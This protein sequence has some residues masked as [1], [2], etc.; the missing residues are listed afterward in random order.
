MPY[1]FSDKNNKKRFAVHITKEEAKLLWEIGEMLELDNPWPIIPL[2]LEDY[3]NM[4]AVHAESK[5][6]L[7]EI[8]LTNPKTKSGV[9]IRNL[10]K[11]KIDAK[12]MELQGLRGG[13]NGK[14]TKD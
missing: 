13:D 11:L 12:R 10:D 9:I 3:Y 4:L 6:L 7:T 1:I 5:E 2:M 8:A 14:S